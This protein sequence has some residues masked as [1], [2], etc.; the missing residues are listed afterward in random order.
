MS[1]QS[2]AKIQSSGKPFCIFC[3]NLNLDEKIYTS[4]N[5]RAPNGK[6]ICAKL[7]DATCPNC[8]K[9][10]H[11]RSHCTKAPQQAKAEKPKVKKEQVVF[12][13]TR[14]VEFPDLAKTDLAKTD[15]A[16]TESV[17]KYSVIAK[18]KP[19]VQDEVEAFEEDTM[20][21]IDE[22]LAELKKE[23]ELKKKEEE[24]LKK[25]LKKKESPLWKEVVNWCDW[26]S[27]Y[28]E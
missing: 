8:Q 21:T 19:L 28:E 18:F 6:I 11:T 4:H 22:K 2:T 27:D 15:L 17:K 25:E 26:D 9:K 10:G 23:E 3:K 7:L 13:I 24:E 20:Q 12:K 5:C 16:K 14:S 1:K